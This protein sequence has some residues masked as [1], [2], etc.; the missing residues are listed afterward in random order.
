MYAEIYWMP[1]YIHFRKIHLENLHTSGVDKLS[2]KCHIAFVQN[3]LDE[4]YNYSNNHMEG[5]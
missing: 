3:H 5:G 2:N 4:M 1:S